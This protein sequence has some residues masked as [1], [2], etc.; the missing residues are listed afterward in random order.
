LARGVAVAAVV[1]LLC[2]VIAL[3]T[4]RGHRG[5][6]HP[7]DWDPRVLDIVH[8]DEQHRGLT[9][10]QPVFV[11]FLDAQAYSDRVRTEP[12][13]L[14]DREKKQLAAFQGELRALGLSNSDVDLLAATNDLVDNGTLA[15]YDPETE[16]VTVRGEEMTVDLRV[17]LVHELTHVLQDQHFG[18]STRRT[19]KF[20]TSQESTSFRTLLEGDAV[21]IENEYIAGLSADDKAKYGD[22]HN[23]EVDNATKGL[24]NV[25]VVL[26]ALQSAPY[27]IGPPF[28]DVLAADGQQGELDEAFRKPPTTDEQV[29][30]PPRFLQHEGALK[31]PGPALPSSIS[32]DKQVDNGDFGATSWL[33]MLGERIDPLVA[34]QAV[35]G[36]GGDAYAAYDEGGGKTCVIVNWQG[37]TSTDDQEMHD[38]LD[39]WV[40]AMP[41]AAGATVTV[42]DKVLQVRSCDPGTGPD[43]VINNRANDVIQIPGARSQFMLEALQ[44]LSL[45]VDKA[46]RFGDCVVHALGFDTF[47]SA[48]QSGSAGLP[49]EVQSVIENAITDCSAQAGG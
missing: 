18:T 26:Q 15:F 9:F 8:F 23:K 37:D 30:D 42:Q 1:V 19:S 44:M 10:K 25:P 14:T 49:P 13:T 6:P 4:Y 28:V 29:M 34:L 38:A 32:N 40:A 31:V 24:A 46:F 39:Q 7:K 48:D 41:A 5:P 16:R 12:S 22:E 3:V 35:D 27:V 11:D 2:G 43:A 17:T 21:R 47:V 36:W 33:L 20:T 45:P